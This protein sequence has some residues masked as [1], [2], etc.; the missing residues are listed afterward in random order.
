[1]KVIDY[2]RQLRESGELNNIISI[3]Q[4]TPTMISIKPEILERMEW[5]DYYENEKQ[6]GNSHAWSRTIRHFR[7]C[8]DKKLT[9]CST[10]FNAE[11]R[12]K[13]WASS[14]HAE[15]TWAER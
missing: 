7:D 6:K 2:L 9:R 5:W 13:D 4:L 15:I 10:F 8:N 3:G 12:E 14:W 11:L 1:M